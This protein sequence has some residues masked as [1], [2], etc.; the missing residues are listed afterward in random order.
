MMKHLWLALVAGVAWAA[1]AA[2]P[3]VSNLMAIVF[4]ATPNIIP[5][6]A[7][8]TSML[9]LQMSYT[10]TA[11]TVHTDK[12]PITAPLN[13]VI[14]QGTPGAMVAIDAVAALGVTYYQPVSFGSTQCFAVV[15]VE[16]SVPSAMSPLTCV[17]IP[18][19]GPSAPSGFTTS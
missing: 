14:Y 19:K 15:A 5:M 3:D 1:P 4:V 12:T 8:R 17:K 13:Y 10:W 16:A 7:P 9:T 18:S 6:L 2:P 11:P